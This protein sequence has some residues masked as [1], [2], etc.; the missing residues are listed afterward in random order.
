MTRC[1][2]LTPS[3]FGIHF[4]LGILPA[5]RDAVTFGPMFRSYL[6]RSETVVVCLPDLDPETGAIR[7]IGKRNR[8]PI[9]YAPRTP[10]RR[11]PLGSLFVAG[12]T[13][14]CDRRPGD[15]RA[16]STQFGPAP[17]D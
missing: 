6:C 7:V 3:I 9:V 4:I 2:G 11:S 15:A 17:F 10:W 12:T 5:W 13:P 16:A 14:R 1:F 8:E